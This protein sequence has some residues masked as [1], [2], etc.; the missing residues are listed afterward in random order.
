MLLVYVYTDLSF[1][2]QGLSINI[3]RNLDLE[4][5]SFCQQY[6]LDGFEFGWYTQTTQTQPSLVI[7]IEQL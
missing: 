2:G 4:N 1:W 3:N 5:I 7:W 6:P